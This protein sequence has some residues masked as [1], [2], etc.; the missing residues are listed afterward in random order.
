MARNSFE[1]LPITLAH[2]TRVERLTVHH[3]DPFDRLLA[4]Q[5]LAEGLSLVSADSIFDQY[6][7]ARLW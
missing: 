4:V 2:A 5:A 1:L 3:R 6:G 7:V